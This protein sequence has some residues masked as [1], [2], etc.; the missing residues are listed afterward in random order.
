MMLLG[1]FATPLSVVNVFRRIASL[2]FAINLPY[3]IIIVTSDN[4]SVLWSSINCEFEHHVR[5]LLKFD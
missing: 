2:Q 1:I 4:L 3:E 5:S